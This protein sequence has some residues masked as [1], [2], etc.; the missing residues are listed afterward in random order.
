MCLLLPNAQSSSFSQYFLGRARQRWCPISNERLLG[1]SVAGKFQ[2]SPL[3]KRTW[4]LC[5]RLLKGNLPFHITLGNGI[6]M[7]S[8]SM[9]D[10]SKMEPVCSFVCFLIP[11]LNTSSSSGVGSKA[12]IGWSF[13]E[14]YHPILETVRTT[15]CLRLLSVLFSDFTNAPG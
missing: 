15:F 6:L 14:T 7:A 10:I 12:N 8:L 11:A 3:K 4:L 2:S 5:I 1:K 13:D 9:I